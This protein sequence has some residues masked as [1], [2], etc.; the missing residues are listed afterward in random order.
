MTA[1]QLMTGQGGWPMSVFLTPDLKPF[2][3]GT[4]FPPD[5]RYGRPGFK[6]VLLALADAWKT[7]RDR[8]EQSA[9]A[10]TEHVQQLGKLPPADGELGPQLLRNAAA[11]LGHVFDP[12]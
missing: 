3:G 8:I 5:D 12:V 2:Y 10:L 7:Q 1:V 11:A 6:R 4:Y 9:A